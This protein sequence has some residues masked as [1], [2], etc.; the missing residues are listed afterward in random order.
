M[1]PLLFEPL[2]EETRICVDSLD[3]VLLVGQGTAH[4]PVYLRVSHVLYDLP[5]L[6]YV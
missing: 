4:L 6:D 1:G 3:Y 2:H 5:R